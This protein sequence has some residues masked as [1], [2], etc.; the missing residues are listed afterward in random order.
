MSSQD[1]STQ[2][3]F[4][5]DDS[6]FSDQ[7]TQTDITFSDHDIRFEIVLMPLPVQADGDLGCGSSGVAA[8]GRVHS[9]ADML[10]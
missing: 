10:N 8:D 1:S 6:N 2:F 7:G 4:L 9:S 5:G 3:H